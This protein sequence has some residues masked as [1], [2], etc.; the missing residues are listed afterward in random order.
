MTVLRAFVYPWTVRVR[1]AHAGRHHVH[2]LLFNTVNASI[3]GR[4]LFGLSAG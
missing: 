1:P 4:W 3:N 2:G